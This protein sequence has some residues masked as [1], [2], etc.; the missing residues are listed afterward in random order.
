M[1]VMVG[2]GYATGREIAEFFLSRGPSTGLVG[3]AMTGL[4]MGSVAMIAFELARMYRTFDYRTFTRLF[5]GRLAPVF[6]LGYF[7]LLLLFLSVMTAAAGS[8]GAGLIGSP[9]LLN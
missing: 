7:A 8:L 9:A 6:E 3:M 5:L 1:A 4:V 2:G